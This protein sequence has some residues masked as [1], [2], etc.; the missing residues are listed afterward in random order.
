MEEIH[1]KTQGQADE[2]QKNPPAESENNREHE[3]VKTV[4]RPRI[5]PDSDRVVQGGEER[6]RQR[7]AREVMR[8][9]GIESSARPE[10][11]TPGVIQ[12][13]E[14]REPGS[15]TLVVEEMKPVSSIIEDRE[16]VKWAAWGALFISLVTVILLGIYSAQDFEPAIE[17]HE[18]ELTQKRIDSEVRR[19][20]HN[21]R[22]EKI[23]NALIKAQFQLLVRKDYVAAEST[24]TGAKQELNVF[25]DSLQTGNI[26]ELKKIRGEIEGLISKIRQGPSLINENLE[27]VR[28]D[29]SKIEKK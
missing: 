2:T 10:A 25:I 20:S 24:L 4:S 19:L 6:T 27:K 8:T 23:E 15:R 3:P 22:L 9:R 18:L 21:S 1:E 17:Y 13:L 14:K 28:F 5:V 11:A 7:A 16:T 29:F 12:Q 26:L